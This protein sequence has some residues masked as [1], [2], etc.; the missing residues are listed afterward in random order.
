MG[1]QE[2]RAES[3]DEEQESTAPCCTSPA[4]GTSQTHAFEVTLSPHYQ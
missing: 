4:S 1:T 3:V 2:G